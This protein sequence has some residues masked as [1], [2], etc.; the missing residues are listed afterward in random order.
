M[1][2]NNDYIKTSLERFI[3]GKIIYI[4]SLVLPGDA[5]DRRYYRIRFMTT[6]DKDIRSIILMYTSN[7][8]YNIDSP[9]FN[10]Y[11]N[12]KRWGVDVPEIYLFDESKGAL[13]IE[14]LGNMTLERLI[15][16]HLKEKDLIKDI[17]KKAVDI[18]IKIQNCSTYPE[19]LS[20]PVF[21]L[22]FDTEKFMYELN[23]FVEYAIEGLLR[24]R[25]KDSHREVF[26]N[27]FLLISETLASQK[28][29]L[30]H[31]D[32]HSRNIMVGKDNR[33]TILDFQDARMGLCQYDLASLLRDSYTIIEDS[34]VDELIEYFIAQKEYMSLPHLSDLN[35][36]T[37]NSSID[38]QEFRKIFDY[39]SI[40]RNLKA[41]GTFAFQAH[42]KGKPFYKQFI[43]TTFSY[44][45]S[46]LQ[47]YSELAPLLDVL[48]IYF[49]DS[50]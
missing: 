24:K 26:N 35:T 41:I 7:P 11:Y 4:D 39:T 34:L 49:A 47:K 45:V 2:I 50:I 19:L 29:Y 46:N 23:F 8:P 22:A 42:I 12:F 1:S 18:I 30:A 43:S 20:S 9:Y 21:N 31:R 14:D 27:M 16:N 13:F 37:Y 15:K 3:S 48:N 40:Q 28:R 33:L 5:S 10:I 44:A 6:E 17:Y 38:R 32:F 25:V 36:S